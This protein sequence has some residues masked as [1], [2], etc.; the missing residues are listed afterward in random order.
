[1]TATIG[2]QLRQARE[3]R[4]LSLEQVSQ[5][6]LMRLH[7]L[8]ALEIGDFSILPS[9]VQARGFLR[10]YAGFLG[11]DAKPLLAAM[12]GESTPG[13]APDHPVALHPQESRDT[14]EEQIDSIFVEIGQKLQRQRELLGLSLEDVK[15]HT[16]L[17]THYL[18]A[19]E[20]GILDDLPSPVQGRGMLN[21]Y[22]GFLGLDSERILLRFAEG[23]QAQLEARQTARSERRSRSTR[24][25]PVLPSPLRRLFSGDFILGGVMVIFLAAFVIWAAV[26]TFAMRSEEQPQPTAPS[27]AEVLLASPT[28]THTPTPPLPTSTIPAV[29]AVTDQSQASTPEVVTP[30]PLGAS[31]TVQVYVTVRQ[32]AWMRATVDGEVEFEGR[33]LPGTA[34]QFAGEEQV[35][36]LTGNAAALQIFFNQQDLGPMGFFGEVVE[37]V[38]T[39][40][41][42][43]LPTP[44]ITPT[45]TATPQPSPNVQQTAM[46]DIPVPPA[47]R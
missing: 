17:R 25:S 3:A 44:T 6:T 8:E 29:A 36:I 26:R 23:L 30:P 4:S 27:I 40:D 37:R 13:I 47:P 19:L 22:A 15:R 2:Q 14:S 7:Y 41:G 11:L 46:P 1:M 16:H 10:T 12:E 28:V 21:N 9:M 38:Y 18:R 31:G 32:R 43:Q 24:W 42:I 20:A 34:Y 33:V 45:G 35:E 39:V 5:A